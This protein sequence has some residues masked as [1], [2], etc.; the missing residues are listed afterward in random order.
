ME[1]PESPFHWTPAAQ[2]DLSHCQSTLFQHIKQSLLR[3]SRKCWH[4]AGDWT[5]STKYKLKWKIKSWAQKACFSARV[6]Y[7]SDVSP[8]GFAPRTIISLSVCIRSYSL[9]LHLVQRS[10]EKF[11]L[12]T[13]K[14]TTHMHHDCQKQA[15]PQPNSLHF[16]S[17]IILR[18]GC[19][20]PASE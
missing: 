3:I 9:T 13:L 16:D 8:E 5:N 4:V 2:R 15:A 6:N 1:L 7:H 11:L 10:Y 20:G 14:I 12:C 19:N 18:F 17:H